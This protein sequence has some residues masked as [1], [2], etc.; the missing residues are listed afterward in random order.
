VWRLPKGEALGSPLRLAGAAIHSIAL[1]PDG[2]TIAAGA[3]D[4]TITLWNLAERQ[5][6]GNP[7]RSHRA[8]VTSLSFSPDGRFLGS[9]AEDGPAVLW[10][11]DPHAWKALAE[12]LV[13]RNLTREE[14]VRFVGSE[15]PYRRTFSSWPI[16]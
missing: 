14:W 16:N 3:G 11:V 1:S 8:A 6:I 15:T 5:V 12:R 10:A 9:A 7:L 13:R 4:G 2:E